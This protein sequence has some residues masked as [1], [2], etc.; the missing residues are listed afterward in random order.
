MGDIIQ[1]LIW[2]EVPALYAALLIEGGLHLKYDPEYWHM[3]CVTLKESGIPAP[4]AFLFRGSD[5]IVTQLRLPAPGPFT[6]CFT[7]ILQKLYHTLISPEVKLMYTPTCRKDTR[8]EVKNR[9]TYR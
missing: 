1:R 2:A 7:Y 5:Y 3:D 6:G 9:K 4:A 8:T